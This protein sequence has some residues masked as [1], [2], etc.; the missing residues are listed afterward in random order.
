MLLT[1]LK[2]RA[3]A[4]EKQRGVGQTLLPWLLQALLLTWSASALADLNNHLLAAADGDNRVS[5]TLRARQAPTVAASNAS[6]EHGKQMAFSKRLGVEVFA[7]DDGSG[8]CGPRL[9]L[10]VVAQTA[11]VFQSAEFADLMRQTGRQV[12]EVRCGIAKEALISGFAAGSNVVLYAGR[13][14]KGD[15]WAVAGVP[16]SES[17][18][19]RN[20]GS[21]R[22]GQDTAAYAR[23]KEPVPA[24]SGSTTYR[25]P[26]EF[27]KAAANVDPTGPDGAMNDARYVGPTIPSAVSKAFDSD[28][29]TWRCMGG[30]V[31][32][33]YLGASGRA[34]QRWTTA[35]PSPT[36]SVRDWCG[37]HPG[38]AVPNAANDTPWDWVCRGTAP[39]IDSSV[40][41]PQL[42]QRGYFIEAWKR[43]AR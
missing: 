21:G 37:R 26:F 42:D 38:A 43:I 2:V 30:Q 8:W 4:V 16:G 1:A 24:S 20:L 13:A 10:R 27:C 12:I 19:A 23:D 15:G 40:K 3:V 7:E 18:D 41:Q 32:G 22:Q 11:S 14:V 17:A 31:Y 5:D 9:R 36:R 29:V 39:V 33:C 34:C 6:A 28:N 35:K 25:D